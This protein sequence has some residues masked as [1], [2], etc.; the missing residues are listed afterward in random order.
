MW[1][2][3]GKTT[4]A[5]ISLISDDFSRTITAVFLLRF[6]TLKKYFCFFISRKLYK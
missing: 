4:E 3:L 1:I 2:T 6:N 5:K